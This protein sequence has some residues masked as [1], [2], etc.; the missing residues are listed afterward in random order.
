MIKSDHYPDVTWGV[1]LK[2]SN[3][4]FENN[5][6]TLPQWAGFLLKRLIRDV[7]SQIRNAPGGV[8]M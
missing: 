1:K 3:V 6:L 8:A 2:K 5:I 4:G 7:E